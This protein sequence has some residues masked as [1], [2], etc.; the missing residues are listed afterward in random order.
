[1]VSLL[2]KQKKNTTN[3]FMMN[4]KVLR[5]RNNKNKYKMKESN[6]KINR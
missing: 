2:L 1:M 3:G 6:K 5:L 4:S